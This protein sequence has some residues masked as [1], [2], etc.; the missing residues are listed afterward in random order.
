MPAVWNVRLPKIARSLFLALQLVAALL[1]A[2]G[3]LGC[4]R[5]APLRDPAA[6]GF[7]RLSAADVESAIVAGSLQRGWIPQKIRPGLIRAT[8]HV[9]QHTATVDINYDEDTFRISYLNSS[10][11]NYEVSGNQAYIH[12]NYNS[13]VDNLAHDIY[14]ALSVRRQTR[15]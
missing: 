2:A 4:G 7:N 6:I 3:T 13:W 12:R 10:N 15:P 14:A 8:L 1:G 5:L 11:L 9:R